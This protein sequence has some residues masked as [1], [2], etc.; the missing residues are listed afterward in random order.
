MLVVDDEPAVRKGVT[1]MLERLGFSVFAAEDGVEAVEIFRR[2]GET[3]RCVVCDLTMPRMGGWQTLEALRALAPGLPVILAS[4]YSQAE[5]MEGE[6][7][8]KPQAFL[9]KPFDAAELGRVL[10]LV[11]PPAEGG[12]AESYPTRRIP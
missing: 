8:E 10:G 6:H 5:V 3:I 2:H 1:F 9:G 11:L 4:G 7:P 12:A